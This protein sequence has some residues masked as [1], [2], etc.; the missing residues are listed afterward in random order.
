MQMIDVL[1]RLAELDSANPNVDKVAM[2]NEQSLATV[3]N[4]EGDQINECGPMG[5]DMGRPSMPASFSINASA[6]SSAEVSSMLRDIMNLAGNVRN[7]DRDGDGDHDQHDH[8]L[9]PL[10]GMPGGA[11][12]SKHIGI[13]DSMNDEPTEELGGAL[14]GGAL[15]A[16]VG[17]PLGALTGA[18]AGDSLTDPDA[19]EVEKETWDNAP[20]EKIQAHKYGDDQVTPKRDEPPKVAGGGN[21]YKKAEETVESVALRLLKDYQAFV[22]EGK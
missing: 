6:E 14:A 17:G 19:D 18:A 12:M 7:L 3:T 16:V 4:I 1:K 22:N 2:T 8:D 11:D 15:G 21:P 20:D 13:I 5:M 10:S 9:E